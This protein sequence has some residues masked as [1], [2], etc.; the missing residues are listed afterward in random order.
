[1]GERISGAEATEVD[2]RYH[3]PLR[4]IARY[5]T[6]QLVREGHPTVLISG[7]MARVLSDLV[8]AQA[9]IS[10]QDLA[11]SIWGDL[12]KNVLRRRWDMQ[13]VRFRQ[14]LRAQG[15]REDLLSAD[16]SGLLELLI[17]PGD[18]VVDET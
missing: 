11:V 8:V 14:K 12:D 5:D 15:I 13:L 7:H 16:G 3:Q 2:P 10:W 1:V 6:V 4:V 17:G 9:P 18:T